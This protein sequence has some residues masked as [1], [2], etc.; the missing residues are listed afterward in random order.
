MVVNNGIIEKIFT[1]KGMS[2]NCPSDPF[3]IS[4]AKTMIKYLTKNNKKL[5]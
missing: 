4:D 1:E 2:N 3:E 5:K